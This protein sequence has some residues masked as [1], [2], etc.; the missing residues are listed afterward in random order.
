MIGARKSLVFD[1]SGTSA[2]EFAIVGPVFLGLAIGIV[3]LCMALFSVASLQYAVQA[4]A[5]CASVDAVDCPNSGSTLTYTQNQYLG[6]VIAPTFT[7][8]NAA[9]GHSVTGSAT[10]AFNFVFSSVNV[11]LSATAC[12][13]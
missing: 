10:F 3:Y 11:P 13:P 4:G 1:E 9:C 6:P 7:Y 5:R 12:F 2:I 8:A